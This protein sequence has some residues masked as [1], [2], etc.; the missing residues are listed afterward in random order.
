M[1]DDLMFQD[2]IRTVVRDAYGALP[3]G[4]GRAMAARL[5]TRDQLAHVPEVAVDWSLGVG[6][7]VAHAD[8]RPGDTVV[9]LGCGGGID[10]V[11]A[12]RAVGPAGRV[13]GV[14]ALPEMC[15]RARAAA[16][17]AGV[18]DRCEV[19]EGE[20]EEL[21][22]PDDHADV[23]ISNGVVNLSHRKSRA[24]A[25]AAR[26]TRHGGRLCIADLTVDDELPPDILASGAA[27]AGCIAGALSETVLTRKLER[28]GFT[29]VV[30]GHR[31]PFS[32][33][34]CAA[35]PLFGDEVLDLMRR[36]LDPPAQQHIAT[37][38]IVQARCAGDA[39]T[40]DRA[41]VA[42]A[43]HVRALDDVPAEDHGIDGVSVRTLKHLE[44]VAFKVLEI[45]P[46]CGTPHHTHR[47]A[48]EGMVVAGQ[49]SLQ[50]A[51]GRLPLELGDV[52]SVAPTEPHAL[53]A[54]SDA[55]LRVA[56]LDCLL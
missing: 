49:G 47:H 12:A 1:T 45:A 42:R 18:A 36:V 20:M 23:V 41:P 35:Y 30:L 22:L 8:L 53:H 56:C 6:N 7:P 17:A 46:A 5:Y 9:D 54:G 3:A 39:P 28:A 15:E 50:V 34:D 37:S 27:W 43:R 13:V 11:L 51:G 16:V 44:D 24:L 33:D 21:P 32:L 14:D 40:A 55:P 10:T 52:F 48:H 2:R 4:A 38:V 19:V 26:V 29:A 25:E 31:L